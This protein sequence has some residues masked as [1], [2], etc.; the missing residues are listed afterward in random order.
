[1]SQLEHPGRPERV[2]GV[3]VCLFA[4]GWNP[5]RLEFPPDELF[6]ERP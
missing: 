5:I 1:M 6:A 4:F 2:Y 3:E